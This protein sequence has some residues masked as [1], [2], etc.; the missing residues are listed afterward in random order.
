MCDADTSLWVGE[1]DLHGVPPEE[2]RIVSGR[3]GKTNP[4]IAKTPNVI[5][6][7]WLI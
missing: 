5:L 6:L 4:E 3:A 1:L 7:L 2:A